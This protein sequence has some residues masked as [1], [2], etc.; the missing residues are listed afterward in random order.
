VLIGNNDGSLRAPTAL[1]AAASGTVKFGDFNGDGVADILGSDYAVSSPVIYFGNGSA[2]TNLPPVSLLTRTTALQTLDLMKSALARVSNAKGVLGAGLSRL[3]TIT[4]LQSQQQAA[5]SSAA[6]SVMDA[7]VATESAQLARTQILQQ[8][9]AAILAS[10]N[11]QP[12]LA[13]QLMSN[14]R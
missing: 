1:T 7:D 12:Q 11:V 13:L 10:A 5:F 14:T 6:S 4:S 2:T 3:E 8:A 9:G